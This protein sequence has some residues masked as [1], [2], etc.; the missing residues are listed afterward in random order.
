M[1]KAVAIHNHYYRVNYRTAKSG[2]TNNLGPRI[3]FCPSPFLTHF[4]FPFFN[5]IPQNYHHSRCMDPTA[6]EFTPAAS[7]TDPTV[8]RNPPRRRNPRNPRQDGVTQP[9]GSQ[10]PP[11]RTV[12]NASSNEVS[13]ST[14]G[15]SKD[16]S[17]AK[18]K[19]RPKPPPASADGQPGPSADARL[20][21]KEGNRRKANF[22]SGLTQLDSE[23]INN[24]SEDKRKHAPN[25]QNTHENSATPIPSRRSQPKRKPSN[26]PQGDDLTSSLIRQFSTPPYPDCAICFSSI[27]PDHAIWSCSPSIP[28]ITSSETQIQQYCWSSFHIKCIRAW[29][30]KSVKEVADAWRV[31]GETNKRGDWRCP[32]CQAKREAVPSGYWYVF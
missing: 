1:P 7:T 21:R 29:A 19:R 5:F 8:S 14:V 22:G 3:I 23:L 4:I 17:I 20:P 13:S 32:G 6:A 25:A 12:Q 18:F 30:D 15:S 28:I 11:K 27:R 10:R 26:L 9:S 24:K 31:R 16:E 2:P